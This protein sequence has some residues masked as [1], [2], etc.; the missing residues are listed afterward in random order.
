LH[1]KN[2]CKPCSSRTAWKK[3]QVKIG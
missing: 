3:R 2:W 1:L